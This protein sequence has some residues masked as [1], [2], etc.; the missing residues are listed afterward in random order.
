MDPTQFVSSI[1]RV[2]DHSGSE[3]GVPRKGRV[4]PCALT[5]CSGICIEVRWV[6]GMITRPCTAT[7]RDLGD[8]VVQIM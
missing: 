2:L 1:R 5:T 4:S 7:M 8:G 6:D 3:V